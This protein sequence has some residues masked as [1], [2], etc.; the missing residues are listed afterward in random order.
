MNFSAI[1]RPASHEVR[2]A[3]VPSVGT[4]IAFARAFRCAKV[5]HF[6]NSPQYFRNVRWFSL[7]NMSA[8]FVMRKFCSQ[9]HSV[10]NLL[11]ISSVSVHSDTRPIAART[12]S[13]MCA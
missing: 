9:L 5:L 7:A 10:A 13:G 1:S 4:E 2:I 8:I 12:G 11:W 6:E 3:I